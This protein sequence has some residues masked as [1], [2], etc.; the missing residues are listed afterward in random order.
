MRLSAARRGWA[1]SA[2]MS[3]STYGLAARQGG[4]D[5]VGNALQLLIGNDK[6]YLASRT[7]YKLGLTGPAV[8][9]QTA[10]S[11]SLVAVHMACRALLGRECEAEQAAFASISVP[12]RVGYLQEEGA[13][14]SPD[15]RCR[16]F[17]ADANGTVPGN[18]VAVVLLKRLADA[19]A[20]GNHIHAVI[21]ASAINNDGHR[22]VGFT[23][24]SIDG[25]AAVIAAAHSGMGC[26]PDS[27]G[28]IEAHGTGTPLGDM[29]E[30]AALKSVF[31]EVQA[32]AGC[33]IGSLKT[34]VGH[35]TPPPASLV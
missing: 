9:V 11:T 13:I 15:G 34:N 18:G 33:A 6:D 16:A 4:T 12:H 25:Q 22:K 20:D 21:R 27:I 8:S 7:A 2:G 3:P 17:D 5:S 14:T 23:A 10:C 28:Y 29:V 35:L 1:C 24:P 32:P 30:I 19:M 26:R 31:A